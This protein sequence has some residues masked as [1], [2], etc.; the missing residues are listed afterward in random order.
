M[1]SLTII[2]LSIFL[3]SLLN[4]VKE[5]YF[6]F[7][8]LTI[9]FTSSTAIFGHG[10]TSN[11]QNKVSSC[12]RVYILQPWTPCSPL[13][14]RIHTEFGNIVHERRYRR[15]FTIADNIVIDG[16]GTPDPQNKVSY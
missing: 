1:C 16:N 4:P 9:R 12:F 13:D 15:D 14:Q 5:L 6:H 2:S 7:T 11:P 10:V 8:R 3:E